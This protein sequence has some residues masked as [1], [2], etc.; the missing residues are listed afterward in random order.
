MKIALL[1]FAA[2]CAVPASAQVSWTPGYQPGFV[3]CVTSANPN[4]PNYYSDK[5]ECPIAGS[6]QWL[7]GVQAEAAFS[8]ACNGGPNGQ[9]LPINSPDGPIFVRNVDGEVQLTVDLFNYRHP[10]A[11]GGQFTWLS[12]MDNIGTGGGPLPT[13]DSLKVLYRGIFY[14]TVGDQHGISRMGLTWL[15]QWSGKTLYVEVNLYTHPSWGDGRSD[16][17]II[18]IHEAN[19]QIYIQMNGAAMSPAYSIAGSVEQTVTVDFA[20]VVSDLIA[21][22]YLPTPIEGSLKKSVVVGVHMETYTPTRNKRSVASQILLRELRA[23]Q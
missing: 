1:A 6:H 17:D 9:S 21:R 18:T 19:D 3:K 5:S 22:G 15:G 23:F 20:A 10:C 16:P 8:Q 7:V 13:A 4:L 11:T 14:E 2:L 12:W